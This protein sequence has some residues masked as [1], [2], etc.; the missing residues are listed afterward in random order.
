MGW[1]DGDQHLLIKQDNTPM[2]AMQVP[3]N[4]IIQTQT[5]RANNGTNKLLDYIVCYGDQQG[6]PDI[7]HILVISNKDFKKMFMMPNNK[8]IQRNKSRHTGSILKPRHRQH[9]QLRCNLNASRPV[10][11]NSP[12]SQSQHTVNQRPSIQDQKLT[13]LSKTPIQTRQ[14]NDGIKNI[15]TPQHQPQPQPQLQSGSQQRPEANPKQYEFYAKA[16]IVRQNQ[17]VGFLIQR[18][19]GKTKKM[20]TQEV[21]QLCRQ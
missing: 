11:P 8:Y 17:V 19:D 10:Y 12:A 2:F 13:M 18:I 20:T 5:R 16:R 1:R 15:R 21:I 4:I 3:R 9:S 7:A 14:N 6:N